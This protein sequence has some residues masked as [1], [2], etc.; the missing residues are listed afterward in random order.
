MGTPALNRSPHALHKELARLRAQ[1]A[2]LAREHEAL[3]VLPEVDRLPHYR[4]LQQHRKELRAFRD[5]LNRRS[6]LRA[7][8]LRW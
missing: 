7:F 5:A 2:T 8:V 3:R 1:H 6:D 4:R